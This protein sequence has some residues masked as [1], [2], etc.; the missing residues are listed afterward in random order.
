MTQAFSDQAATLLYDAW[1][2]GVALDG[3]PEHLRPLTVAHGHL[4][5]KRLLK[6]IGEVPVGWKMGATSV[7]AMASLQLDEPLVGLLLPSGM[8]EPDS[9][10]PYAP[11]NNVVAV[12][13]SPN[14][15]LPRS[16]CGNRSKVDDGV[17]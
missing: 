17:Q 8:V 12:C 11:F 1:R 3:L 5:Q 4:I 6:L 14:V 10:V 16:E 2:N 7:A 13:R 15:S 9:N